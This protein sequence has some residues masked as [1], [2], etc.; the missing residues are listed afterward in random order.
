MEEMMRDPESILETAHLMVLHQSESSATARLKQIRRKLIQIAILNH[1]GD[2]SA[3]RVVLQSA[4]LGD[5]VNS[6]DLDV[7]NSLHYNQVISAYWL[8]GCTRKALKLLKSAQRTNVFQ[9]YM[10]IASS[11]S[12]LLRNLAEKLE[13]DQGKGKFLAIADLIDFPDQR[14]KTLR[15]YRKNTLAK[16]EGNPYFRPRTLAG[17]E[18]S[19]ALLGG[20]DHRYQ[21]IVLPSDSNNGD[22]QTYFYDLGELVIWVSAVGHCNSV[23]N[24]TFDLLRLPNSFL[25]FQRE[26]VEASAIRCLTDSQ[27]KF[28]N[29]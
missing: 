6:I 2:R 19:I 21:E 15:E 29:L 25:K 14:L 11:D 9:I 1:D 18:L 16:N 26:A 13:A 24:L 27:K 10:A 5:I 8:A 28:I 4:T 23:Q 7:I 17:I 12:T 20:Q 22:L 3:F